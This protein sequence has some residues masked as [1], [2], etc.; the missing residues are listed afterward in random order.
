MKRICRRTYGALRRVAAVGAPSRHLGLVP[1]AERRA[2][3]VA[4]VEALA[5]QVAATLGVPHTAVE[6]DGTHRFRVFERFTLRI[7]DPTAI[8]RMRFRRG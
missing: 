6:G 5:A 7:K 2:D 8:V 3:A 1:V 4:S